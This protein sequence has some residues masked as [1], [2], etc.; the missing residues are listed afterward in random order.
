MKP[1]DPWRNRIVGY[2]QADPR[3][4]AANPANWRTHPEHQRRALSGV[5]D[6]VGWVAEVLVNQRTGF[7]V[8]GHLRVAAALARSESAVPVRYV[9]LEP[10]EERL[11]LATLDPI[12]ALADS[13]S[14]KLA[15][16]LEDLKPADAAIAELLREL[17]PPRQKQLNPDDA[18]LTP[19]A[20]PI[21]KPG[22]LW[23][24]GEHRLL[25]G[26]ALDA[27]SR[28]RLFDGG[29]PRLLVT[30][31]PY[32]VAYDPTW[33]DRAQANRLAPGRAMIPSGDE[34][35]H[36]WSA[37]FAEEFLEVVYCWAPGGA[38][39]YLTQQMLELAGY[40]VRQQIIWVKP[41]A[42]LSRSAYHWRHEPCWYGVRHGR[43][44]GWIAA[45]DETTVWEAPSPTHIMSGSD[46]IATSHATQKPLEIMLR[47]IRNHD[48]DV[49]DPFL[50]SGTTLIAAEQ[51]D[52]QCYALEIDPAYCDVIVRRWERVTGGQAVKANA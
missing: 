14:E 41:M 2:G 13:D 36:D 28:S 26:D 7:V 39:Q 3:S 51:L 48:G 33:R 15:A 47:P 16:L 42:P 30:D 32:G 37:A 21:T 22:D 44:A 6:E 43:Q 24:L 12:S 29:E 38:Q 46:E 34:A 19:P 31:P 27:D 4:L 23:R 45:R 50:G 25:C 35:P 9:D 5:L 18:D 20:E 8:D 52:R 1:Q 17:A 40:Q 11:V 49:Y 10:E